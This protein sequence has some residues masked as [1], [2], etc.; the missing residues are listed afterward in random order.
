MLEVETEHMRYFAEK[1]EEERQQQLAAEAHAHNRTTSHAHNWQRIPQQ[2]SNIGEDKKDQVDMAVDRD[3]RSRSTVA[4]E[5]HEKVVAE[6]RSVCAVGYLELKRALQTVVQPGCSV[7]INELNQRAK[8]KKILK[9]ILKKGAL[10]LNKQTLEAAL[11][12]VSG[13]SVEMKGGVVWVSAVSD[14]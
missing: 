3:K 10:K 1:N 7:S 8:C 6:R 9:P 2:Q 4:R 12:G 11:V 14:T 13:F 5:Q